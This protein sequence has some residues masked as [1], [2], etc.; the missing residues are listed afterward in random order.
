MASNSAV[1][2]LHAES[3]SRHFGPGAVLDRVSLCLLEGTLTLLTGRNGSG[4]TTLVN[5]LAGFDRSYS[6]RVYFGGESIDSAGPS[7]RARLGIVRTFQYPH[8][9]DEFTV[10]DHLSLGRLASVPA[11]SSYF[12]Q[13]WQQTEIQ[14]TPKGVE[15]LYARRGDELSFGEMKLVNTARAIATKPRVLLLDEPLASLD[16]ERRAIV[17]NAILR[18][19]DAGCSVLAVEHDLQDLLPIADAAF[20]LT[21]GKMND[22]RSK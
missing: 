1:P 11:L 2:V 3:L 22:L 4:K 14:S 8:L 5:C 6:G 15:D 21:D 17:V 7:K 12:Q 13:Q 20:E 18:I 16:G 10:R 9:F 19:R